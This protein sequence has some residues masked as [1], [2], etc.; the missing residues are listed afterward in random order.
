[1]TNIY[2]QPFEQ[3]IRGYRCPLC[4]SAVHASGF[5]GNPFCWSKCYRYFRYEDLKR[6][7]E[8]E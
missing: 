3:R 6:I 5:N 2:E 7:K 4:N 1:M 8:D